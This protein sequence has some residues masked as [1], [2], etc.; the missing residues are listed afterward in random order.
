MNLAINTRI[1]GE[2]G[3]DFPPEILKTANKV[4]K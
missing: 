3:L 2:I 1:A 4:Y